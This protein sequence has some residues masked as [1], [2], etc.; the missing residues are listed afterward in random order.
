MPVIDITNADMFIA[1]HIELIRYCSFFIKQV[2]KTK[3]TNSVN[4]L[5]NSYIPSEILI[6][7]KSDNP[8]TAVNIKKT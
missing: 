6:A 8:E 5:N 2:I 7:L 1:L 3:N 4:N